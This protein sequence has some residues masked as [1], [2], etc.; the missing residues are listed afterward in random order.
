MVTVSADLYFFRY[1]YFHTTMKD[2]YWKSQAPS[3]L[4]S[5]KLL[6]TW[7]NTHWRRNRV[8]HV[9]HVGQWPTHFF[10]CVGLAHPLL[11]LLSFVFVFLIATDHRLFP[12][13]AHP[14]SK[15]FRR[16][17][18]YNNNNNNIITSCSW[19]DDTKIFCSYHVVQK[20]KH[21]K[22]QWIWFQTL[23]CEFHAGLPKH[24]ESYSFEW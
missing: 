9:G 10:N 1:M 7:L 11:A 20:I 2:N 21:M 19:V 22:S 16:R 15:S 12:G 23:R 6:V 18:Q 24:P 3:F 13:L 5:F 4:F 14:L 8:G 17:C